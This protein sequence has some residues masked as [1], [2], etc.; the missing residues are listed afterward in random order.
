MNRVLSHQESEAAILARMQASRVELLS[1]NTLVDVA[2]ATRSRAGARL[3]VG[4]IVT[5]LAETPR[6]ALLLAFCVGT[7]VLGPKRTLRI[8]GRSGV[9]AWVASSAKKFAQRVG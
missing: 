1:A 5:A 8:A 9:T 7:V 3:P 6:V 4:N 2:S